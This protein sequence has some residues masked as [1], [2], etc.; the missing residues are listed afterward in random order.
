MQKNE[1]EGIFRKAMEVKKAVQAS[2]DN[3]TGEVYNY[4]VDVEP[5]LVIRAFDYYNCYEEGTNYPNC[6]VEFTNLEDAWK[7]FQDNF[8]KC[9]V[10]DNAG[11]IYFDYFDERAKKLCEHCN[12]PID[13]H[14]TDD[15]CGV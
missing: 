8:P 6:D 10:M 2:I 7:F 15:F 11:H 5:K 12:R 9:R 13:A 4:E 3:E 14:T 1:F